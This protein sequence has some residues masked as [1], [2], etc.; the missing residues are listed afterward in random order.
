MRTRATLAEFEALVVS[1]DP[2]AEQ[3]RQRR[4]DDGQPWTDDEIRSCLVELIRLNFEIVGLCPV[5][6]E[7]IRRCDPRR[8]VADE[9]LAH[10]VCLA[11][12]PSRP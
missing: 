5:C 8:L 6:D 1:L 2:L 9:P 11:E 4:H 12:G 7:P 3:M 10:L